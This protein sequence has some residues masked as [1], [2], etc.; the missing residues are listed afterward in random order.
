M[1]CYSLDLKTTKTE[2][3]FGSQFDYYENYIRFINTLR[4]DLY[5]SKRLELRVI[6]PL[7]RKSKA[8]FQPIF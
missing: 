2:E 5:Q 8:P 4:Q 7:F 6:F 1:V 3:S